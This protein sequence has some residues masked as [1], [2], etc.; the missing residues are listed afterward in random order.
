MAQYH[1]RVEAA[2]RQMAE[3]VQGEDEY[4]EVFQ[5][6][7]SDLECVQYSAGNPRV[8]HITG[9]VHLY[10]QTEALPA[11]SEGTPSTSYASALQVCAAPP[12]LIPFIVAAQHSVCTCPCSSAMVSSASCVTTCQWPLSHNQ[13]PDCTGAPLLPNGMADCL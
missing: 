6:P 5:R 7:A 12:S 11:Q 8:E 9:L 13:L 4:M 1:V 10:K 2:E 3:L